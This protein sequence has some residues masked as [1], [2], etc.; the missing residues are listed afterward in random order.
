VR[1][2]ARRLAPETIAS[3]AVV[4]RADADARPPLPGGAPATLTR[5][6]EIA[7][8]LELADRA[9]KPILLGRHLLERGWSEGPALGPVL[10]AAFEAQ[11]DGEFTDLDGGLRWLE[12]R[13]RAG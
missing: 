10:A 3:L 8:E 5:L 9:P 11:L 7:H 1:R 12:S 4:I 2:L 13:P 6:L